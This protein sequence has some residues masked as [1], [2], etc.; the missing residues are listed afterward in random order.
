M[1]TARQTSDWS[2]DY[3]CIKEGKIKWQ[4]GRMMM[5]ALDHHAMG[6][7]TGQKQQCWGAAA[8]GGSSLFGDEIR[9]VMRSWRI[10]FKVFA[11][12]N[13]LKWVAM[14]TDRSSQGHHRWMQEE[15]GS[16]SSEIQ[17]HKKFQRDSFSSSWNSHFTASF[18]TSDFQAPVLFFLQAVFSIAYCNECHS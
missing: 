2:A 8:M 14:A 11:R 15:K 10:G 5:A 4:K 3:C 18:S 16:C 12:V 13:F 9:R 1:A 7:K 6:Q 17:Q